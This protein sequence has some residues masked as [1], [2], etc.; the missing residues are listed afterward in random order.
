MH[1]NLL[2]RLITF[3]LIFTFNWVFAQEFTV[4]AHIYDVDNQPVSFANVLLLKQ[5][6]S[7]FVAGTS[8][9]DKGFLNLKILQEINT[10]STLALLG[11]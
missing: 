8:T 2:I 4:S 1:T 5:S 6:D 3:G 11:L 9:D 10:F 7:S